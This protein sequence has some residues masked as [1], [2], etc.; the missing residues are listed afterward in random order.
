MKIFFFNITK[1]NIT[2]KEKDIFTPIYLSNPIQLSGILS[3]Y[4]HT[5]NYKKLNMWDRKVSEIDR[6]YDKSVFSSIP[7]KSDYMA[8]IIEPRRHKNLSGVLKNFAS[9]LNGQWSMTIFHGLNN[10]QFVREIIGNT[11]NIH[12][13]NLNLHDLTI[14]SYTNLIKSYFFW[15]MLDAKKVLI[16]QSDTLLRNNNINNFL[17]YDYIGAPWRPTI[18][19]VLE[20][21]IWVGNGGLSIRDKQKSL[22]IIHNFSHLLQN[23]AEDIFF[24][25][26]FLLLKFN[27]ASF[28]NALEFSS[29][30]IYYPSV[31]MHKIY[32]TLNED[33]VK[34]LLDF[35]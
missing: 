30:T 16:F 19:A 10:Q 20:H 15:K 24:S 9:K 14:D 26:L 25:K 5:S 6:K 18:P 3:R 32:I 17:R 7:I 8:V 13:V 28:R 22:F 33:E 31:G 21:N 11:S 2:K 23:V 1:F 34:K 29:E 27:I 35:D 4:K 12:L